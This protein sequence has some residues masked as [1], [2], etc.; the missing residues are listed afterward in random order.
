MTNDLQVITPND[1]LKTASPFSAEQLKIFYEKTPSD[2]IMTRPA[3]GGGKWDYVQTGHVIDTLNR[4]F[5]YFWSFEVLT[6]LE[7]A[8]KIAASGTCVVKGR[9][10]VYVGD[11]QLTKDA[12]SEADLD[13]D[14][15]V[16]SLPKY[17]YQ[18]IAE[19]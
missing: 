11:K 4:V 13:L 2:K 18:P 16:V 19:D 3:K 8:A 9:L 7:E 17:Y 5:G 10:T 6:G 14:N 1:L 12:V 15:I